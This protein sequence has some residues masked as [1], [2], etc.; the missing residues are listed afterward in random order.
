[1]PHEY[2]CWVDSHVPT[3]AAMRATAP[4]RARV[5]TCGVCCVLAHSITLAKEAT[6][7]LSDAV[8]GCTLGFPT[9]RGPRDDRERRAACERNGIG[10]HGRG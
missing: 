5:I 9:A 4:G 6:T 3:A 2:P 1:M 10:T 8:S 7:S